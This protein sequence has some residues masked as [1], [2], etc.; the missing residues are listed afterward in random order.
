[1]DVPDGKQFPEFPISYTGPDGRQYVAIIA[2]QLGANAQVQAEAAADADSRFRRSGATLYV[3]ALPRCCG[4]GTEVVLEEKTPL[5]SQQG[6]REAPGWFQR[7][8][9]Q[10]CGSGTTPRVIASQSR[11]PPDS[12]GQLSLSP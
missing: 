8:I 7:E 3:F 10:Q 2:S 6:W 1:V 12:G 11:C 5:L 9:L 4:N